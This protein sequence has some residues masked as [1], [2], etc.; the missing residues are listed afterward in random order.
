MPVTGKPYAVLVN[1]F[2]TYSDCWK[3]FFTLLFRYWDLRDCKVY[4]VT[5]KKSF[6]HPMVHCIQARQ[7]TWSGNLKAA[8]KKI[9]ESHVIYMQE[10]YFLEARVNIEKLEGYLSLMQGD[11]SIDY[12]ELTPFGAKLPNVRRN[13]AIYEIPIFSKYRASTQIALWKKSSLENLLR[14]WETGWEFEVYGSLRS[15][16]MG[17][18]HCCYLRNDLYVDPIF[19]YQPTG[20]VKGKWMQFVYEIC[21]RE[22]I[23]VDFSERGFHQATL[24]IIR[25]AQ[26]LKSLLVRPSQQLKSISSLW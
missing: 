14:P 9:D 24:P 18:R 15:G 17:N 20:I 2:D 26:L 19:Q 21:K 3:P 10:D 13:S 23:D 6:N 25:R 16:R 4:L 12:L 22:N 7:S 5:D 1:S 11:P 8:L